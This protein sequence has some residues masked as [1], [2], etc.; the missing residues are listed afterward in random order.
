MSKT[1]K[2][3]LIELWIVLLELNT[4]HSWVL[5]CGKKKYHTL[6]LSDMHHSPPLSSAR[7]G[8]YMRSDPFSKKDMGGRKWVEVAQ[9]WH[10]LLFGNMS[11]GDEVMEDFPPGNELLFPLLSIQTVKLPFVCND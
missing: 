5:S 9:A 10:M 4:T 7:S 3:N 11:R 8:S 6:S 1:F 2:G